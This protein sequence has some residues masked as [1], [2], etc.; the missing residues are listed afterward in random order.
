MFAPKPRVT[1]VSPA[2]QKANNGNWRTAWR[3]SQFLRRRCN[4][5]IATDWPAEGAPRR[6]AQFLIA[7]HARRSAIALERF[8]AAHPDRPV[9]LVLTG[10]DLYGDIRVDASAQRSL[11]LAACLVV[12]QDEGLHELQP[13]HRAKCRVIYQSARALPPGKPNQRTFDV[14]MVGHLRAEK[15]PLTPMRALHR[16]PDDSTVRLIHIGQALDEDLLRAARE[17]Q[18]HER[19]SLRRYLWLGGRPHAETRGRIRR[20][21]ALVIS[22]TME[23]GANVIVEAVSSGVPVIASRISGN[24]G[25]LG[26]DYAGYFPVGDVDAL[27]A[28][29]LRASADESFLHHLRRQ[30][31]QR[32]PLFA[33]ARE[34][35]EVNALIQPH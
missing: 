11:D 25:M 19:P 30:C 20:A 32:A 34:D 6:D 13:E 23:G 27:S 29:L 4:V 2:L 21:Q 17:L 5:K 9:I 8:A 35:A 7:L 26:R 1:I 15:D 28:L 3:W 18:A 22:S 10:T 24:V 31:A 14:I 33:P 16:L 12:L